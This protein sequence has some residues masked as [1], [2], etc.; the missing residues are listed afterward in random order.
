MPQSLKLSNLFFDEVYTVVPKDH[1]LNL[2]VFPEDQKFSNKYVFLWDTWDDLKP[3]KNMKKILVKLPRNVRHKLLTHL[4]GNSYA[5]R[6]ISKDWKMK[7]QT[8]PPHYDNH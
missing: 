6:F 2:G 3:F 8:F 5:L 4:G 7:E 1:D